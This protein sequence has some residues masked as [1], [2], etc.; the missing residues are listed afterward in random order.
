MFAMGDAFAHG[1]RK[2]GDFNFRGGLATTRTLAAAIR[3]IYQ[4][5][6]GEDLDSESGKSHLGHAMAS[7]AMTIDTLERR[8][9]LDDRNKVGK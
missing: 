8:P 9:D 5:L 2:Y 6:D 4:F 3:H 1:A 7:L